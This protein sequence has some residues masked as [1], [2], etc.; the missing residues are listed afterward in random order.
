MRDQYRLNKTVLRRK[1]DPRKNKPNGKTYLA[2]EPE[3]PNVAKARWIFLC[4]SAH[5]D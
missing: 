2:W 4:K 5:V 3:Q 1:V